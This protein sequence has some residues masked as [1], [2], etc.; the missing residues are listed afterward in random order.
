V[1]CI[2]WWRHNNPHH[3]DDDNGHHDDDH[4]HQDDDHGNPDDDDSGPVPAICVGNPFGLVQNFSLFSLNSVVACNSGV[5]GRVASNGPVSLESYSIGLRIREGETLSYNLISSNSI[6][7]N[8]G[9][10][11]RGG[12]VGASVSIDNVDIIYQSQ[13]EIPA[14]ECCAASD[15]DLCASDATD[16]SPLDFVTATAQ[17]TSLDQFW[18]SLSATAGATVE[19]SG[20]SLEL[21]CPEGHNYTIFSVN[22]VTELTQV[23]INCPNQTVLI[24]YDESFT[25]FTDVV[26]TFTPGTASSRVVHHFNSET[27]SITGDDFGDVFGTFF[28][29]ATKF[30][31]SGSIL[32]GNVIASTYADLGGGCNNG[33]IN[34]EPF[35]GCLPITD[36][37]AR[38]NPHRVRG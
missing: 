18:N 38:A 16:T 21:T 34:Y 33:K 31:F 27:L 1:F 13:N 35:T 29:P 20:T 10:L 19:V 25:A 26:M 5:Q 7:W 24:N 36:A 28:A 15:C 6:L 9:T 22:G 17:V 3:D 32:T 8:H 30:S 14:E 23:N 4:G 11:W 37:Q 12:V 2:G